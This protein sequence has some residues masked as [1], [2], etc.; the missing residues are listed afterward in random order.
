[1]IT[2]LTGPNTYAI[3]EAVRLKK[4]A[5]SGETEVYDAG[6]LESRQ[7]PDL[8]MG[9]S[10][11]S[12]Q[13][14]IVIRGVATN[15]SLWTDLEQWIER[16]P[17]ESEI[18]LIET[19]PDKRTRTYKQLQKH[20]T[21][22]EHKELD[23]ITLQTWLQTYA[24]SLGVDL[25]PDVSKFFVNRVGHDQWRLGSELE[26]LLLADKPITREL[27]QDIV[28][29]YPEATAFELLDAVFRR[30]ANRA[31]ELIDLLTGREDPYQFFGLLSSQ[32]MALLALASS[33]G[34]RPGDIASDIGLHPFVVSKLQPVAREFGEGRLKQFVQQLADSDAKIKT[35]GI[36][37]WQQ[38]R[39]TLL[40]VCSVG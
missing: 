28:E 8:F 26:K 2:L 10:L 33:G 18:V 16:V 23:G 1:M 15:K 11:F 4:R 29:P 40:S 14:L 25:T 13:R 31:Q 7:L 37:P 21:V 35:S 17:E 27:I 34:R 3:A 9:A 30:D 39:L 32:V 19:N 38:L 12:S 36:D 22:H 6:D 24:R 5:F 20:G